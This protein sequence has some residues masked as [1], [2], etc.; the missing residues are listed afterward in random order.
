MEKTPTL[1]TECCCGFLVCKFCKNKCIQTTIL[2]NK[3][4]TVMN[5]LQ[6]DLDA[7]TMF[8]TLIV[9]FL[10]LNS[11]GPFDAPQLHCTIE[12]SLLMCS[13]LHFISAGW[14]F[15]TKEVVV[16]DSLC[17]QG[18]SQNSYPILI[19]CMK[20][21]CPLS[22]PPRLHIFFNGQEGTGHGMMVT[23]QAYISHKAEVQ[24]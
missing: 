22:P 6:E 24:S 14:F 12:K 23:V 13:L 16:R 10:F 1:C 8:P 9:F 7:I 4:C 19:L 20:E 11:S 21:K 15:S 18:L 2:Q 3:Y 5:M 17:M